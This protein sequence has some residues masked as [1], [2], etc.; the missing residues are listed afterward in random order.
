MGH[1]MHDLAG[2]NAWATGQFL[3]FCRGLDGATLEAT[4][5]GTYCSIT[6]TLRH[7]IDSEMSY[8]FRLTSARPEGPWPFDEAVGLRARIRAARRLGL[9]TRPRYRADDAEGDDE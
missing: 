7:L 8:L 1:G 3:A 5:P 6:E 2:H 9:G 4:V